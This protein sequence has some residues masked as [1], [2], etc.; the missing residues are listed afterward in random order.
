V[1][2]S[3]PKEPHY[4]SRLASGPFPSHLHAEYQ[5]TF[6]SH[7]REEHRAIGEG[8]VSYLYSENAISRILQFNP[9]AKFIVM[10]RNPM[11]M[12]PSYHLRLLYILEEDKEDFHEAWA[13][14]GSRAK[15]EQI[16][17]F[18]R[19]P[20]SLQYAEVGMLGKRV[21]RLYQLAGSENCLVIVFNDFVQR[22][23]E[24]YKEVLDFL[25]VDDD[26]QTNFPKKMGSKYYRLRWLQQCLYKPPKKVMALLNTVEESKGG[27]QKKSPIRKLRSSLKRFNIVE[28]RPRPFD[29]HM[30][31]ILQNTFSKD[32][33]KLSHL[34]GRDLA[35]IYDGAT[36]VKKAS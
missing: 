12:L 7:C 9:Q 11:E 15:G 1:G 35:N 3:K 32:I 10:V 5:T 34:L 4:F 24:V 6:F 2:F 20:R 28:A 21:E 14:Q 26:G 31:E 36:Q 18:C 17:R 27:L 29:P 8:S 19:D 30:R 22:T 25:N 16:P 23:R 33:E 13:L